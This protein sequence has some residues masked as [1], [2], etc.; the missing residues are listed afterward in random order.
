MDE[1]DLAQYNL[2]QWIDF[3]LSQFVVPA[4]CPRCVLILTSITSKS[5]L[6]HSLTTFLRRCTKPNFF[7]LSEYNRSNLLICMHACQCVWCR[8]C[9]RLV[10]VEV[11]HDCEDAALEELAGTRRWMRCPRPSEFLPIIFLPQVGP[12]FVFQVV[13]LW[14]RRTLDA[15][16]LLVG[17]ECK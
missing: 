16:I 5:F 2:N 15:T 3:E 10:N 17:V 9:S 14:L 1:L 11:P 13:G 6:S 12:I 8:D 7:E 4:T